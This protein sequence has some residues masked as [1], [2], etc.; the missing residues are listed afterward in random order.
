M[1]SCINRAYRNYCLRKTSYNLVCPNPPP[2]PPDAYSFPEITVDSLFLE[3]D[4]I[5][6]I[7]LDPLFAIPSGHV[8][9]CQSDGAWMPPTISVCEQVCKLKFVLI[10]STNNIKLKGVCVSQYICARRYILVNI[11]CYHM[12]QKTWQNFK[13]TTNKRLH[14]H[15]NSFTFK[16]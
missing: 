10:N 14:I 3:N 5:H 7:C 11:F 15:D 4:E 16:Q 13:N 6:Y 1:P 12:I 8:V 2:V 9:V